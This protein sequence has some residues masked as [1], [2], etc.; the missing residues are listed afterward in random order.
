MSKRI[1]I[2]KK[3]YCNDSEI[4]IKYLKKNKFELKDSNTEEDEYFTDID[5]EFVFNRTCLRIRTTNNKEMELTF[6]GKSK[7][8][9][10]MYA[11][12]ENNISVPVV[13]YDSLKG[14][15]ASLGYYSYTVVKK[16]RSTYSYVM[17][18]LIYNVMLDHIE[19][20]GNFVEFEILSYDDY[21]DVEQLKKKLNDMLEKFSDIKFDVADIPYRDFV[22]EMIYKQVIPEQKMKAIFFDLDGT[23]INSEQAFYQ[24]MKTILKEEY[25]VQ[26]NR[27][28]YKKF[29]LEK[30]AQLIPYLQSKKLLP[31][32]S[33][34]SIMNLVYENYH[35]KFKTLIQDSTTIVNF[36]LIK[37][38][39]EKGLILGIVSTSKRTFID[40][41]LNSYQLEGVF[42]VV[43][44]RE[45]VKNLKPNPEAYQT[46]ILKSDL[47]NNI[48]AVLA[49]EDSKRGIIAST[50]NGIKTIQVGSSHLV[51]RIDEKVVNIDSV[52]RLL[53]IL[54]V[55]L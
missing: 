44:G 41:L 18:D 10:S 3:F 34:D 6:K 37:R 43:I 17:D 51:D 11:K 31:M 28:D 42:D 29:E 20:I 8:L 19:N 16:E 49:V 5:G 1:E 38:L 50:S 54:N 26:I 9:S 45:D 27:D 12:A 30:N 46:A 32:N 39:K 7:K 35:R 21:A 33:V 14:L 48:S 53:L 36:E 47:Q 52:T 55:Y 13:E 2:E 25:D 4:L 23:L 22:A 40:E 24:S 15:L